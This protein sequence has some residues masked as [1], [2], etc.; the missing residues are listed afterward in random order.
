MNNAILC[1]NGLVNRP[2]ANRAVPYR[3][4]TCP[5]IVRERPSWNYSI[6]L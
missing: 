3:T 2:L 6:M 1:S 5:S 4:A